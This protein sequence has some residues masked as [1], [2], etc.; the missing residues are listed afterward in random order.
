MAEILALLLQNDE[1]DD[2]AAVEMA[3]EA[4]VPTKAHVLNF[5]RRLGG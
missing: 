4:G 3:L 5:L 2:L 1:H